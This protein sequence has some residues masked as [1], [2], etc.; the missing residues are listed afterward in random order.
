MNYS[1]SIIQSILRAL[2]D[3]DKYKPW[4]IAEM[5]N[6]SRPTTNHYLKKLHDEK[7][8]I[9]TGRWAHVFYHISDV[10]Y[11]P[12][13]TTINKKWL[14]SFS[15]TDRK[16]LDDHFLKYDADGSVLSGTDG[17][18]SWCEKRWLDRKIKLDQYKKII[19]H[20]SWSYD[21]CGVL[22]ATK[23]FGKHVDMLALDRM[24]YTEQYTLQDFW[25][26]KLA[27]MGYMGKQLQNKNLLIQVIQST[28]SKI[29]SVI[30]KY[31]IDAIAFTPPTIQRKYQ[32]LNM[33]NQQLKHIT[34]PRIRLIKDYP[35]DIT[36]PQK[37]LKKREDRIIN[38]QRSIYVYDPHA[39][40]YKNVLLIDDFV[41]SGATMNE[42]AKKLK[43][44]WVKKIIWLAIVGNMDMTYDIITEM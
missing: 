12:S 38:A 30:I 40:N 34:L 43:A 27:E 16:I 19:N 36:I 25:R 33:L 8:I 13:N 3:G 17:F 18:V 14:H 7:K 29:E 2:S 32:I 24:L 39:S 9:K 37:S 10:K 5:I 41:W 26:S 15:Y 4:N 35:T 21:D 20:L 31:N 1:F 22:D 11:I 23:D 44:E 28:I 6:L 42:T